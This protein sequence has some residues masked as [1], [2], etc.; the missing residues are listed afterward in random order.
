MRTLAIG[1]IHGC[2]R[3]LER[4][5]EFVPFEPDDQIV[6]LGD[7]VDRG[8]D[9]K[10]VVDWVIE[11]TLEGRCTP[12]M[13]NHELM[14]LEALAGR[15]PMHQWLGYGGRETLASYAQRGRT[16]HPDCVTESHL[17]FMSRQ[18]RRIYETETHIFA[19]AFVESQI[20]AEDQPE[21]S[22]FWDR[23][24]HMQPHYSGKTVVVGHT[25]QKSGEPLNAGHF[26]CIDTWVYGNGW[27]TC[28][29]VESGQYWQANEKGETRTDWLVA[30]EG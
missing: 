21:W 22:L 26:I 1:D 7:Y 3:S 9:S 23:C 12:L 15:M 8:P 25:A 29:D 24:D 27:L 28:L 17:F 30:P 19:H 11:R 14:M 4:L 6:T 10:G 18:L 5:A 20:P 2:L 13:G 16:P